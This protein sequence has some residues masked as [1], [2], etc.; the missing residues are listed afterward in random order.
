MYGKVGLCDKAL[1]ASKQAISLK[2]DFVRA[3]INLGVAY[4]DLGR[5]DEAVDVLKKATKIVK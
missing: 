4:G 5:H 2:P 3:Y 1:E